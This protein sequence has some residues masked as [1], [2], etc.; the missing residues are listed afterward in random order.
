MT[1]KNL[2]MTLEDG[3][4]S[5]CR[6]PRFSALNIFLSAS[7]STLI[8]TIAPPFLPHRDHAHGSH[9]S[10]SCFLVL[11]RTTTKQFSH[12]KNKKKKTGNLLPLLFNK[13]HKVNVP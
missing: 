11:E 1:V 9:S 10:Y 8:L 7:F 5:T 2:M 3:F 6:L 12:P 4:S 13:Q